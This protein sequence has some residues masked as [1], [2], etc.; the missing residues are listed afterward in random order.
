VHR[1]TAGRPGRRRASAAL[2]GDAKL[3]AK[4]ARA[5]AEERAL[6][7]R[8]ARRSSICARTGRAI[9]IPSSMATSTT[10]TGCGDP[11]APVRGLMAP[12]SQHDA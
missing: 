2:G 5:Y 6:A 4:V 12:D 7:E 3:A 11:R 8:D 1:S 9:A 10:S